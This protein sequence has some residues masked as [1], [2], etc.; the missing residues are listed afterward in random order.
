MN[1]PTEKE[2]ET[3][4]QVRKTINLT[5]AAMVLLAAVTMFMIID[6][7][8]PDPIIPIN[9]QVAVSGGQ[10]SSIA[11]NKIENGIH[12]ATGL[13][14]TEGYEL[15]ALNCGS[16]HSMKLVT[17]NRNTKKGWLQTIRWMQQSQKLWDLGDNE[18]KILK[19]LSENYGPTETGRRKPLLVTEWYE[20]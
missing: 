11:D 9:E 15:V 19:Y 16:C 13:I 2:Q 3:L 12:L 17:Q 6:Q 20:L 10:P 1:K 18:E 8:Y 14:A 5:G 4:K 7:L